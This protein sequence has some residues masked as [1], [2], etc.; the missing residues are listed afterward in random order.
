[1][2][3]Y[4]EAN[5]LMN[6]QQERGFWSALLD[7][8]LKTSHAKLKIE[9]PISV[10]ERSLVFCEDVNEMRD[11]DFDEGD[12]IDLLYEDFLV[13]VKNGQSVEK[14]YSILQEGDRLT[15][16]VQV[17]Q[18][19]QEVTPLFP[20]LFEGP[21][22]QKKQF[23]CIEFEIKRDWVLRG[24]W[25]LR[26]MDEVYTDHPFTIEKVIEILYCDFIYRIQRGGVESVIANIL[27]RLEENEDE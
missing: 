23:A 9:V 6:E 19:N 22:K 20:T 14:W 10:Y 13:G 3:K 18:N 15:R 26:D 11:C 12:L 8:I 5:I 25:F 17:Y 21:T 16:P 24:E 2:R 4:S 27:K 1:M 7:N